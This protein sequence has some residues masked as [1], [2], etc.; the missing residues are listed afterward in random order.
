MVVKL[1]DSPVLLL[2]GTGALAWRYQDPEILAQFPDGPGL[3]YLGLI[4]ALL[5]LV[6]LIGGYGA[7]LTFPV[8][9]E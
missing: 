9:G 5:P 2:V 4:C 7:D 1:I 3:V 6:G 8:N